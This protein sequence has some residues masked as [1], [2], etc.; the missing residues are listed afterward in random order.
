MLNE[1][2]NSY[3]AIVYND[4]IKG[5][6][7]SFGLEETPDIKICACAKWAHDEFTNPSS[8]VHDI[9]FVTDDLCCKQ[10][11]KYFF[12][13]ETENVSGDNDIDYLGYQIISVNDE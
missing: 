1:N 10:F 7:A 2:D 11:A 4:T 9:V 5:I 8:P 13:M 6:V 12:L 3:K